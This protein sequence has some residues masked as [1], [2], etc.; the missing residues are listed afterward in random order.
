L[1]LTPL[2]DTLNTP[3]WRIRLCREATR[4]PLRSRDMGNVVIIKRRLIL[5]SCLWL[6]AI[7]PRGLGTAS[8]EIHK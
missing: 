3:W 6:K 1:R 2:L 5:L 7:D 8:P 4:A